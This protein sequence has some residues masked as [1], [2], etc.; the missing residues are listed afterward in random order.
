MLILL[1]VKDEC[2]LKKYRCRNCQEV[3]FIGEC[4]RVNEV[5]KC[6]NP[7]CKREIGGLDHI[8]NSN[9]EEYKD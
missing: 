6:A 7:N 3:F 1:A 9:T 2:P 4:G 5:A 8:S